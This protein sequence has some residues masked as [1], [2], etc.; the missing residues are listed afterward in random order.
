[1]LQYC[2]T[3]F[4]ELRVHTRACRQTTSCPVIL[5]EIIPPQIFQ[6]ETIL[7]GGTNQTCTKTDVCSHTLLH[8]PIEMGCVFKLKCETEP[9]LL[10]ALSLSL[11]SR[12]KKH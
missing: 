4:K 7:S 1:M 10:D 2:S 9:R 8:K 5:A 11:L 12:K 6:R 3:L